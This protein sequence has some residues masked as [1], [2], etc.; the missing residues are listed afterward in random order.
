MRASRR[1]AS[2]RTPRVSLQKAAWGQIL[3]GDCVAEMAALPA[4]SVDLVFADPPYN[5][6]LSGELHRPDNSRVDG[7]GEAWDKFAAFAEYDRFNRAWLAAARRL[8]KPSGALWVIGT[9]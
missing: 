9:Y 2:N 6:Q 4:A 7:V 1:G 3:V 8:L 5:L